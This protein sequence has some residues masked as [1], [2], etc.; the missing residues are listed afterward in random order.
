MLFIAFAI[1]VYVDG[2]WHVPISTWTLDYVVGSMITILIWIA[3]IFAIPAAIG[4]AWWISHV[5]TKKP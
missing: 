3:A 2:N 1:K 4:L 5:M